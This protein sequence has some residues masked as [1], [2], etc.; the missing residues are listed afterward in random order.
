MTSLLPAR[1]ARRARAA[2][3]TPAIAPAPAAAQSIDLPRPSP[4]AKVTQT[5]GLTDIAI[6][7]SSPAVKGRI[8]FGGIVPIATSCGARARTQRRR[9]PSRRT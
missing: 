2:A 1:G 9:S 3:L 7:Y 6:E 4:F 8:V 5:V